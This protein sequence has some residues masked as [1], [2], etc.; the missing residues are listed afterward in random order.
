LTTPRLALVAASVVALILSACGDAGTDSAAAEDGAVTSEQVEILL[1]FPEGLPMAPVVVAKEQGIFAANGLPDVKVSVADGS[2]Y[3]SQQ[4]VSGNIDFALM[5]SADVAVAASKRDDVRVLFCHQANNVYRIGALAETGVSDLEGMAGKTLGITEPGGG[6]NA[7]V[8]AALA[9][10]GLTDQVQT[11]PIGGAGPQSLAALKGGQ[12]Q[13]FSSSYP[14]FVALASEGVEFVDITPTKYAN[15]P[16]TCMTTTEEFLVTDTGTQQAIAV[17]QSWIEAEQFVIDNRDEA[18]EI[19]CGAVPSACENE[20][21]AQA[22]FDEA[23]AVMEPDDDSRIGDTTPEV[24]ATV[25]EILSAGDTVPADLD[26]TA[27][28]SG[29]LVQEVRDA[30]YEALGM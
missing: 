22:L 16:G 6:E 11:L 26:L 24:W 4:L 28:V 3:V 23:I 12:A 5:G 10:A 25:V 29:G 2:G 9:D 27:N 13:G 14:D 8:R 21:A 18:F 15:V 30:A 17:T 20:D 1:P 7:M 19:V